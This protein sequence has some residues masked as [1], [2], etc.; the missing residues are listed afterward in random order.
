VAACFDG[1][2]N[3]WASLPKKDAHVLECTLG[4]SL[5][6]ALTADAAACKGLWWDELRQIISDE[7]RR[8]LHW[9]GHHHHFHLRHHDDGY[10]PADLI[11][12]LYRQNDLA[13][14]AETADAPPR[15]WGRWSYGNEV[16]W[17]HDCI[18]V[19]EADVERWLIYYASAKNTRLASVICEKLV[20]LLR[21][22]PHAVNQPVLGVALDHALAVATDHQADWFDRVPAIHLIEACADAGAISAFGGGSRLWMFAHYT[23]ELESVIAERDYGDVHDAASRAVA[24]LRRAMRLHMDKDRGPTG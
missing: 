15:I 6:M 5:T 13:N 14:W 11:L 19:A 3:G 9:D 4:A 8:F 20:P 16:Q 22:N 24:S 7:N 17:P 10:V 18:T 1:D 12:D 2:L 21:A 23:V